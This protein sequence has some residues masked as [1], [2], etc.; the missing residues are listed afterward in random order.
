MSDVQPSAAETPQGRLHERGE[1]KA[2][3]ARPRVLAVADTLSLNCE[4]VAK[5]AA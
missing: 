2:R 1:A 4:P 3:R 5:E